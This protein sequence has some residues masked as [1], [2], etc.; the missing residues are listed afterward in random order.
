MP[1]NKYG[2]MGRTSRYK[3]HVQM[4]K[5]RKKGS[6]KHNCSITMCIIYSRQSARQ[7][8]RGGNSEYKT[9]SHRFL[10][11]GMGTLLK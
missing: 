8:V 5:V 7:K 10:S 3:I 11:I 1:T 2:F 4:Q 9:D 6:I